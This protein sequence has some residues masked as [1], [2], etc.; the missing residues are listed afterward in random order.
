M[1]KIR[2]LK[3]LAIIMPIVAIA[4]PLWTL[5]V[6]PAFM[7]QKWLTIDVWGYGAIT[8][9]IDSLN[10]ANHYVGLKDIK[11][12]EMIEL[13]ILPILY[14]FMAIINYLILWGDERKYR[15]GKYLGAA[16]LLG[17]VA[18]FQWWLYRYGHDLDPKL[19]RIEIDPFTPYVT[20]YYQIANFEIIAYFN[21][22]FILLLV[23]YL[24]SLYIRRR[25]SAGK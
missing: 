18:Y 11:P 21:I 5:M 16:T 20:G 4:L 9:P 2:I 7:G 13:K 3:I 24:L 15:I 6:H 14:P 10:I 19:A 12:E 22:G 1:D 17:V 23:S 8:G 25:E